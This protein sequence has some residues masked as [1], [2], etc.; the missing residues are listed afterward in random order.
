LAR[1]CTYLPPELKSNSCV[2]GNGFAWLK[3]VIFNGCK[4]GGMAL[5]QRYSD[6]T[7]W[8]TVMLGGFV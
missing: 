4:I 2:S 5:G 8:A 7:G 1:F 6:E 3:G